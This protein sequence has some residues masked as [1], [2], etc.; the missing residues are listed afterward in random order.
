[1]RDLHP[2]AA[3]RLRVCA[4]NAAGASPYSG[5]AAV[6]TP[7]CAPGPVG[8]LTPLEPATTATQLSFKFKKPASH[9][10]RIEEYN[11]EWTDKVRRVLSSVCPDPDSQS[12]QS[13]DPD[14][15]DPEG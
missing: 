12:G 9:G 2:A 3:Y 14:L 15:E 8:A 7:P 10:E 1:M 6:E 13:V 5:C 4:I 11:V